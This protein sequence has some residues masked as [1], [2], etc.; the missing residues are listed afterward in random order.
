MRSVSYLEQLKL[1]AF[2]RSSSTSVKMKLWFFPSF[3]KGNFKEDQMW[4]LLSISPLGSQA[5]SGSEKGSSWPARGMHWLPRHS[6]MGFSH[7]HDGT[8]PGSVKRFQVL[9]NQTETSWIFGLVLKEIVSFPVALSRDAELEELQEEG[10][11]SEYQGGCPP[12]TRRAS[13]SPSLPLLVSG[14]KS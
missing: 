9:L 2:C 11:S 3:F 4:K 8:L 12:W 14:S 5:V 6:K 1:P 10:P 7:A 13:S